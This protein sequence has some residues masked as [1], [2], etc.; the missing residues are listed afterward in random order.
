MRKEKRRQGAEDRSQR[1][2]D[3]GQKSEDPSSPDGFAAAR[4]GQ[5]TEAFDFGF[6]I[7]V[8]RT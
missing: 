4:R 8:Q 5:E 6:G 2:E 7:A 3:R 1:S